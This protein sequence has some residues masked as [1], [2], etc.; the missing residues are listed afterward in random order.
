MV[1][2]FDK[3]T[4]LLFALPL[5]F[6]L[7]WV[8]TVTPPDT[9]A[10]ERRTS[11]AAPRITLTSLADGSLIEDC[12][13]YLTDAIPFRALLYRLHTAAVTGALGCSECHG[14]RLG[15]S[16]LERVTSLDDASIVSDNLAT[17]ASYR[18]RL[19]ESS[20]AFGVLIPDKGV[21][22]R[23]DDDYRRALAQLR[24]GL[25]F[26]LVDCLDTLSADDYFYGDI[27]IR[28]ERYGVLAERLLGAM[29]Q[30]LD[31]AFTP[32]DGIVGTGT[33]ALQYPLELSE[34]FLRLVD[35]NGSLAGLSITTPDGE[36]R[37]LYDAAASQGDPYDY[38]LGGERGNGILSVKNPN[39]DAQKR[40]I[41][42]RDSFMRAFLPYLAAEYG[43][44]LLVDLR[45]PRHAILS[46]LDVYRDLD[47]DVLLFVS[48]HTLFSTRF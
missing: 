2:L 8:L 46:A 12:E 7:L 38:Y 26:S 3:L 45:A 22:T 44:I 34:S 23:S 16:S 33:L 19:S 47:C 18:A 32:A 27:H 31:C 13:R 25:V 5:F 9:I 10:E 4:A 15:K 11:Y 41:V 29:G 40:L 43:E 37:L 39:A 35:E 21:Y 36:S 20:R 1:K 42:F 14:I 24:D 6:G 30:S 28:P 17:I 48:T